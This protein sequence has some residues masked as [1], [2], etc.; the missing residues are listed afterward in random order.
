MESKRQSE[1]F[2]EMV[3]HGLRNPMS[4]M[5]LSVDTIVSTVKDVLG[6]LAKRVYLLLMKV[7]AA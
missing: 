4:A 7:N 3:S 6:M 1:H 5:V 2:I